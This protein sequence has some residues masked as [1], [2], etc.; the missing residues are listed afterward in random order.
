MLSTAQ[1]NTSFINYS[2]AFPSL[3][4]EAEKHLLQRLQLEIYS[5]PFK[6]VRDLSTQ[7]F[8]WGLPM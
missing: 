3:H 5:F 4:I 8:D 2:S 1:E 6:E 7:I